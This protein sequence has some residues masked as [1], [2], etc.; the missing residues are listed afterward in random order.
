[1]QKAAWKTANIRKIRGFWKL[2]EM[3]TMQKLYSLC[4]MV[5]LG[6]KL[7]LPKIYKKRLHKHIGIVLCKRQLEKTANI[8]KMRVFWKLPKIATGQRLCLCKKVSLGQK[9]KVPKRYEKRLYEHIRIV[10]CQKRLEKQLIF[11]KW[12]DFENWQKWPLGKG[13]S[14]CKMASLGQKL[15]VPKTYEKRLYKRIRIVLCKKQVE[16]T[17]NVRKMRVF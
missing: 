14:L 9:L 4:K 17:A 7:K 11:Q 6:Q 12:E 8:W 13:Y 10:L 1:M 16:K 2:A 3:A 5:S 15:K